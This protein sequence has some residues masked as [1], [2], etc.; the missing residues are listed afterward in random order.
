VGGSWGAK[1]GP[2]TRVGRGHGEG[3]R[4][5]TKLRSA[6]QVASWG[7]RHNGER[8]KEGLRAG[9]GT[10]AGRGGSKRRKKRGPPLKR[11]K[12]DGERES[13]RKEQNERN[14]D[15]EKKR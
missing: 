13:R 1:V 14:P 9:G 7:D 12:G 3:R 6:R 8:A 10:F 11:L 4:D 15:R 2:M 5:G